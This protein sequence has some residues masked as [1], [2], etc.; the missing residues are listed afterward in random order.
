MCHA[1]VTDRVKSRM[2]SRRDPFKAAPAAVLTVAAGATLIAGTPKHAGGSG[3]PARI[4]A[5]V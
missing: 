4:L 5:L 2:L 1:C 3:G